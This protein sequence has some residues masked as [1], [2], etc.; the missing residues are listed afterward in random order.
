MVASGRSR[1]SLRS[2]VIISA[3]AALTK[4]R[5][6]LMDFFSQWR[7]KKTINER[8]DIPLPKIFKHVVCLSI[9]AAIKRTIHQIV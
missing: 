4:S 6:Q 5:A 9:E 3:D 7:M 1:R 8:V 2:S